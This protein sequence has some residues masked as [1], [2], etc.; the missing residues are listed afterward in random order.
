MASAAPSHAAVRRKREAVAGGHEDVGREPD[1]E[2]DG[3]PHPG[4]A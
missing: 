1:D 2:P 3:Q 4:G